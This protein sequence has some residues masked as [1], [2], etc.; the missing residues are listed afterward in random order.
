M[1]LLREADPALLHFPPNWLQM[2]TFQMY[3]RRSLGATAAPAPAPAAPAPSVVLSTSLPHQTVDEHGADESIDEA[4]I[5]VVAPK[6]SIYK[7]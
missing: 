6:V 7:E 1:Q 3:V 5:T 4:L 2:G